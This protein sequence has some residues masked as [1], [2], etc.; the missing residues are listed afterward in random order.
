MRIERQRSKKFKCE[1]YKMKTE[2]TKM[3][4]LGNDFVVIDA[5]QQNF[6]P[7]AKL[8]R[9]WANRHRG[10]GFDQLLLLKTPP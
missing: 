10:I 6:K 3:H 5:I 1:E 4:L 8:I 7:N 2:F 9:Q